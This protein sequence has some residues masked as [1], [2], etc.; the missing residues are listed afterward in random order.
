MI[1]GLVLSVVS[2]L[3][4]A[5]MA[6][7]VKLGYAAGLD[8]LELLQSRFVFGTIILFF[9]LLLR[10]PDQLRASR[11]TILKAAAIG[12]GLY[13]AQSTCFFKALEL[14]PAS[15]TAL[16]FYIHPVTVTL[17]AAVIFRTPITRVVAVSL[18]FVMSG[19]ALVFYDAFLKS[20]NIGGMLWA[21][22]AMSV[23]SV[24]LVVCQC[25]LKN[26]PPYRISFYVLVF[27][28]LFFCVQQNPLELMHLNGEQLTIGLSLGIIPTVIAV[29]ML[30]KAI[31]AIGS[32][33]TSIFSTVEPVGTLVL[34]YLL[35]DENVV[36]LQVSGVALIVIGIILPNYDLLRKR[37][38]SMQ[39]NN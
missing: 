16:I 1:R 29:T 21:L 34:A 38:R 8:H 2:A 32:S 39:G 36:L 6:V 24:Y 35:L 30:Y 17:L 13:G 9:Y 11:A 4:Y 15:T 5:S 18:V 27:T 25:A 19:C 20:L 14:I 10:H 28:S 31:E 33:L 3:A 7:L 22:G 26:E 37:Q 12:L 23:F